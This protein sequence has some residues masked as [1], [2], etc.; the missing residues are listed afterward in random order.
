MTDESTV[1]FPLTEY[2]GDLLRRIVESGIAYQAQQAEKLTFECN[3]PQAGMNAAAFAEECRVFLDRLEEL[4]DWDEDDWYEDGDA[5][6]D[7]DE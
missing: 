2:E 1:A 4:F 6:W 7:D 5:P 3:L